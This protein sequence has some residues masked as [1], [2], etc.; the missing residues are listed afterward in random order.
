MNIS[1]MCGNFQPV[2][3]EKIFIYFQ[4]KF[5]FPHIIWDWKKKITFVHYKFVGCYLPIIEDIK[6]FDK[7]FLMRK[8]CESGRLTKQ[9]I[10][11]DPNAA[12]RLSSTKC[13]FYAFAIKSNALGSVVEGMHSFWLFS[14]SFY[15][16][17]MYSEP[18]ETRKK[19][20][21]ILIA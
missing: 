1:A 21:G 4:L 18:R 5:I 20:V 19:K 16:T 11:R 10:L 7:L 6:P 12:I 17:Q 8:I 13:F 15:A 3:D 14:S 2:N 9:S